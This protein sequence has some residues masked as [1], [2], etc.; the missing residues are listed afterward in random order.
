LLPL[1]VSRISSKRPGG[2]LALAAYRM[3]IRFVCGIGFCALSLG[4]KN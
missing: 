2:F 1:K 3:G 4:S